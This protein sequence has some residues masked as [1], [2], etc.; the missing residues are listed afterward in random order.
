MAEESIEAVTGPGRPCSR[1]PRIAE[2]R[3]SPSQVRSD[4]GERR[5]FEMLDGRYRLGKHLGDGAAE[6]Y[7]GAWDTARRRAVRVRILAGGAPEQVPPTPETCEESDAR[8]ADRFTQAAETLA[9]LSAPHL[10]GVHGHGACEL[11]GRNIRYLVVE[12]TGGR[13]LRDTL[14][15][16]ASPALDVVVRWGAQLCEALA[17]LHLAG[18]VH[19]DLSP[20]NIAVTGDGSVTL[21][22]PGIAALAGEGGVSDAAEY[23]SP[24]LAG[25]PRDAG[26]ASDL[27]S[28]GCLVYHL[29][30]GRPPFTGSPEEVLRLHRETEPE[31]S[32]RHAP[33]VPQRLDHLLRELLTKDPENRPSDAHRIADRLRAIADGPLPR[34]GRAPA[35]EAPPHDVPTPEPPTPDPPTTD[36][37]A[38][39]P[40]NGSRKPAGN[41]TRGPRQPLPRPAALLLTA[42]VAAA[43]WTTTALHTAL[44]IP[45]A[46]GLVLCAVLLFA[47]LGRITVDTQEGRDSGPG[48]LGGV[49]LLVMAAVCVATVRQTSEPWWV[50]VPL[51]VAFGAGAGLAA[52]LLYSMLVGSMAGVFRTYGYPLTVREWAASGA[53]AVGLAAYGALTL[54]G[55]DPWGRALLWGAGAWAAGGLLIGLLLIP[56]R[57]R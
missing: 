30:T 7:R 5:V 18:L 46:A 4:T 55:H 41:R 8:R 47:V 44:G 39:A 28:L 36:P 17:V 24:E 26:P 34:S 51:G 9:A 50:G 12:D 43:T 29:V 21:L 1:S 38:A 37:A 32:W 48:I 14:R 27:Y 25:A 13:T 33:L 16:D 2:A 40:A 35:H 42:T 23:T 19:A 3:S 10:A 45:V 49:L 11:T 6:E 15:H 54:D 20:G 56:Y 53:A 57:K 52:V 22:A 31:P